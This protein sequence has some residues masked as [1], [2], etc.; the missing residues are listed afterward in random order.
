MDLVV[1]Y[2]SFAVEK[3]NGCVSALELACT[4]ISAKR[5]ASQAH[6][7]LTGED[8]RRQKWEQLLVRGIEGVS[9]QD[10]LCHKL[11]DTKA[12]FTCLSTAPLSESHQ[13]L[14][15]RQRA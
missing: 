6:R 15:V 8:R 14:V 5:C 10:A 12:T 9:I 2:L 11:D 3:I 1:D 13:P 7:K 4:S